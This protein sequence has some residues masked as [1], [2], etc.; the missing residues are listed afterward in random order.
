MN[1]IRY[2]KR[3]ITTLIGVIAQSVFQPRKDIQCPKKC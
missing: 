3:Y 1:I 2:V